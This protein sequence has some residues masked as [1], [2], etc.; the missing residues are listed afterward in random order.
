[1]ID[2]GVK[3]YAKGVMGENTALAYLCEKGMEPLC[4]RFHS[5]FGEVDL[6]MLQGETLVFVEVKTRERGTAE[7]GQLAVTP[8]KRERLIA[9]A[10][11]YVAQHPQHALRPMRF[12]LVTV[13][14]QGVGHVPDAF[15]GSEW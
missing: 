2:P 8:R 12:D 5:P 13:T 15:E 7:T 4:R 9:T 14:S 10:R 11:Y 6:V 1:M 3:P